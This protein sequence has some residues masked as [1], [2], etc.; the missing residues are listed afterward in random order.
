MLDQKLPQRIALVAPLPPPFGGMANQAQLLASRLEEEGIQVEL[1]RTNTPYFAP[2]VNRLKGIRAIFRLLPY[3]WTLWRRI[4]KVELVHVMANSGWSWHLFAAPAIWIAWWQKKPVVLN[5]HGGEAEAFF[6]KSMNLV[7]PS[8]ERSSLVAVPSIYLKR[9]FNDFGIDTIVVPNIIDFEV[10]DHVSDKKINRTTPHLIVC[11]NLETIYGIDIV[12][13]AFSVVIKE[14]PGA[15]LSVAGEGA[16][17][18]QLEL[19]ARDLGIEGSVSFTGR[20]NRGEMKKLYESADLMLNASRADNTPLALLEAMAAGVPVVTSDA[21]GIP[22]M[23]EQDVTAKIVPIDDWKFMAEEALQLLSGQEQYTEMIV[24]GQCAM[25]NYHWSSV[26]E[27]WTQAY[28]KAG[29]LAARKES[30]DFRGSL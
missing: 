25:K 20:L 24:S 10:F 9:V 28:V 11:R 8:V 3:L 13:Q 4:G 2:W 27:L 19:M 30:V 21:G 15:Q 26:K 18:T 17:R 1:I 6:N 14:I 12:L 22:L 7:Y 29:K 16:E 23:V 5:Y